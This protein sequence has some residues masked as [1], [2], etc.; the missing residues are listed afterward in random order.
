MTYGYHP[1]TI[2]WARLRCGLAGYRM[3]REIG[4]AT[5]LTAALIRTLEGIAR[6]TRGPSQ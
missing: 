4:R 3:V 6:T 2:G 5:G 1:R